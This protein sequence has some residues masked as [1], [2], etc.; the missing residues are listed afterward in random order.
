MKYD[1]LGH[2]CIQDRLTVHRCERAGELSGALREHEMRKRKV[3]GNRK[4]E[5]WRVTRAIKTALA[6]IEK[7]DPKFGGALRE[8]IETGQFFSYSPQGRPRCG[9]IKK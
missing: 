4:N 3:A 8:S 2:T 7:R 1:A 6:R 5:G 9:K